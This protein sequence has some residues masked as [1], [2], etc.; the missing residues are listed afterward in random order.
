LA[1]QQMLLLLA[2]V[3]THADPGA[4]WCL[5]SLAWLLLQS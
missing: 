3:L 5:E 1:L 2:F 4:C